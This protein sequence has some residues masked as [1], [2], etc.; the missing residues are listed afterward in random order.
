MIDRC[1]IVNHGRKAFDSPISAITS[2]GKRLEQK[3][4][5]VI[6]GCERKEPGL[7]WV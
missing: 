4:M 1:I 6:C 7:S 2:S 5:D 3:Y